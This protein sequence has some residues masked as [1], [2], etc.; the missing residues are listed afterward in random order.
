[1]QERNA[2]RTKIMKIV[3]ERMLFRMNS[4]R[5]KAFFLMQINA[6][7]AIY[8]VQLDDTLKVSH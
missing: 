4:G 1:M 6:Q 7:K 5:Q 8:E 2:R 3:I